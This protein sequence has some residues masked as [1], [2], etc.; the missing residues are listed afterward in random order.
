MAAGVLGLAGV[1]GTGGCSDFEPVVRADGPCESHG[2]AE[3]VS[4]SDLGA[5]VEDSL[6]AVAG[7]LGGAAAFSNIPAPG[8]DALNR[9]VEGVNANFCAVGVGGASSRGV[10]RSNKLLPS[11]PDAWLVVLASEASVSAGG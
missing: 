6:I 4:C 3:G 10:T 2:A 7:V 1:A 5:V 9:V 8:V 11:A